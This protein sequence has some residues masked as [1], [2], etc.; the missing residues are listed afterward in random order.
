MNQ[1]YD[2]VNE[3]MNR[4]N[5]KRE[6]RGQDSSGAICKNTLNGGFPLHVLMVDLNELA[7]S[8]RA[9]WPCRLKM[10]GDASTER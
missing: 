8:S 3:S 4:N 5:E 6:K 2:E 1:V 9:D 10:S 7:T